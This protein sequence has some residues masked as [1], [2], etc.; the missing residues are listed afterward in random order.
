MTTEGLPD[1]VLPSSALVVGCGLIGTSLA[2]ALRTRGVDVHLRDAV[3]GVAE[4]AASVGAGT[5]DPVDAPDLVVV[6]VP[7]AVVPETV[8]ALLKE[9]PQAVV[10]DV[11]SELRTAPSVNMASAMNIRRRRPKESPRYP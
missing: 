4:V 2:L 8:L 9:F 11:A 10:T 6:A 7:P 3:P 1:G 5:I